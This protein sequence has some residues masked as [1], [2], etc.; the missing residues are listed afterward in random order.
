MTQAIVLAEGN[1][2]LDGPQAFDDARRPHRFAIPVLLAAGWGALFAFSTM[3]LM[4][5]ATVQSTASV[6]DQAAIVEPAGYDGPGE[7]ARLVDP[8]E[9]RE[10]GATLTSGDPS[11]GA[12]S[13][14]RTVSIS[15]APPDVP[16][17]VEK[18]VA[19][20][21]DYAGVWGP[22]AAACGAKSRRRGFLPATITEDGAKAGRTLCHFRNSRRDGAGWLMAADCSD[23]GRRWTSQVRLVVDGDRLTW[24]SEKGPAAYVRCGRREG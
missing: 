15:A 18:T 2:V 3:F 13:A 7:T 17:R 20:R 11:A 12:A 16:A 4:D 24:S 22:N 6:P 5:E 10:A 14:V 9:I 21:P 8:A 19:E 23:R 1:P